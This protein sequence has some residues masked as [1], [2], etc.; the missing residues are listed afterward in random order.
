MADEVY[1]DNI[2]LEDRGFVSMR[3]ALLDMGEPYASECEIFSINSISK[4]LLGECGLR[5][6]YVECM[7]LSPLA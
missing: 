6:G 3:K 2:Y 5:G 7:N 4:G 1:Q